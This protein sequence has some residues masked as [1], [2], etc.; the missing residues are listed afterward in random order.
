MN[1]A[2]IS[3]AATL[4]PISDIAAS[5][6]ISDEALIPYGH[7]MAKV[8][9]QKV[10]G[11]G[12]RGKLV[13]VTAVSPTPAGEGKSTVSVGIADAL[14]LV[15]SKTMVALREPSLGPVFGMKGGATGGGYAQV[16]PMENINLHFTGDFHAITSAHNL[17]CNL[18][19]NHIF[20]GNELGIDPRTV[21]IKRV[22]DMNDRN[23]RN[24]TI[25]LGGR[26]SGTPRE[27]HFEITVASETMAVFCLAKDI[28]D[29]KDRLSRIVVA[30]TYD[31]KP[32]TAAELGPNGAQGG[33]AIL[34]RD[35][36]K[37]NLVQSIGGTP[38]L[39][40]GGPFANIAHGANSVIATNTALD[41][42]ETVVT[43]AGF[44]ADLG[45]EKF[46]NITGPA[47]GFAADAV[48][49]VATVRSVKYNGGLSL[50]EVNKP[51]DDRSGHI[52][53]MEKGSNN[54]ARHLDNV[55]SY[56]APV[57]VAIN[58]FPQDTDEELQWVKDFCEARGVEAEVVSVWANGGEGAKALATKLRGMLDEGND[59][60]QPMFSDDTGV[61]ARI[62]HIVKNIY[63]GEGVDFS[64]AAEK[65]LKQ[66]EDAG[67]DKVPVCMAKTQY[68]FTDDPKDLGAPEGFRVTVR[69]LNVRAGAGFVVALT[70]AMMT[71][72][73]LPNEPASD[74]MDVNAEGEI[75]GL[76]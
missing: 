24:V 35:A 26:A 52:E 66:L 22:L 70:G 43:E 20:H 63:G 30:E 13:L 34:L 6:N 45:A 19:D 31:R 16:V 53:A 29:L 60:V 76:F 7:H 62:E 41:L 10:Q 8:D 15:G 67:E 1:D 4:Q 73:G 69:E 40:H 44:G 36:M 42:A 72:P 21:R 2:E 11:S 23:L 55:K 47:G 75:L 64:S 18:V 33:M 65:Q 71:M 28:D 25:G 74:N 17:L 32:V 37:P 49:V 59:P 50:D 54:L 57:I 39:I 51:G 68:S 12:K 3:L 38:A 61:R 5:V 46:V 27:D 14:N 58:Q 48:T 56:G 9:T